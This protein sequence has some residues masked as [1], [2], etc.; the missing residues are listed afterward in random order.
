MKRRSWRFQNTPNLQSL[1]DFE[2]S[3][4]TSKKAMFWENW[5]FTCILKLIEYHFIFGKLLFSWNCHNLVPEC[6]LMIGCLAPGWWRGRRGEQ[7]NDCLC[8]HAHFWPG[9]WINWNLSSASWDP[10]ATQQI[11]DTWQIELETTFAKFH[12]HV[13]GL[14]LVATL[15]APTSA[16]TL[17]H[18][19]GLV[20]I[21]SLP[22]IL[23]TSQCHSV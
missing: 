10:V 22:I 7:I 8:W 18:L 23:S 11:Q 3:Y 6:S 2:P 16:F 1:D 21:D 12:N 17:T 5:R 19:S 13:E 9:Y 15:K 20:I 4:G 14:L